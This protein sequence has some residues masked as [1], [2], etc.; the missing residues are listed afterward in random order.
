MEM[1]VL[2]ANISLCKPNCEPFIFENGKIAISDESIVASGCLNSS[3]GDKFSIAYKAGIDLRHDFSKYVKY[4]KAYD[5]GKRI[6]IKIE[7]DSRVLF[8]RTSSMPNGYSELSWSLSKISISYS[9]DIKENFV[10]LNLPY[11]QLAKEV[12]LFG[13]LPDFVILT[14]DSHSLNLRK[15]EN[16]NQT[17]LCTNNLPQNVLDA[18]L[19]HASFYYYS[20]NNII[21]DST[22]DDGK[23][24]MTIHIPNFENTNYFSFLSEL[25]YITFSEERGF[26]SFL[27]QSKWYELPDDDMKKLKNAVYTL[28]RCK[29]CDETTEFLLLYSILDRYAGN[30][31]GTD[32]YTIMKDNLAKGNQGTVL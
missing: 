2:K 12:R 24:K 7:D 3:Q 19:I 23:Q 11:F 17:I 6:D 32:P 18:F 21:Q 16:A 30:S 14:F 1:K 26:K 4:E 25:Q 29:Y 8:F 27:H 22:Y 10:V 9:S 5:K 20:L 28:A 31:Y 15:T 13:D